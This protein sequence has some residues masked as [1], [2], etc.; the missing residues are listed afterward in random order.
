MI[1]VL[2]SS[3]LSLAVYPTTFQPGNDYSTN[4][5]KYKKMHFLFRRDFSLE[6]HLEVKGGLFRS[7]LSRCKRPT[8]VLSGRW[9]L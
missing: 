8:P 7:N 2:K 1:H 6:V 4:T 5:K 3:S 9:K